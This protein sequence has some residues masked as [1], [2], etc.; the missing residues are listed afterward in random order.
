M[1]EYFYK[2]IFKFNVTTTVSKNK[3]QLYGLLL[4]KNL[5]KYLKYII[6]ENLVSLIRLFEKII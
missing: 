1:D 2:N 5:I 6:T 4:I 3:R